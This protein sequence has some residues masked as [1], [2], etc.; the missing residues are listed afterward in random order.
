MFPGWFAIVY[1]AS[2]RR[3]EFL[4]QKGSVSVQMSIRL[5]DFT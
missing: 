3:E 2:A 1:V 4:L 5:R